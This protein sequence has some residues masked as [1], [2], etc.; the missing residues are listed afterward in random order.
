MS[1]AVEDDRATS[2][3]SSRPSPTAWQHGAG[4]P[5]MGN[6]VTGCGPPRVGRA[7][8]PNSSLG[9][10]RQGLLRTRL[11]HG[12]D[13][14]AHGVPASTHLIQHTWNRLIADF[15]GAIRKGDAALR[16][17]PHLPTLTALRS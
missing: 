5:L 17:Y 12:L 2:R 3:S 14:T 1:T 16:N 9:A 10:F 7:V 4:L 11:R 6:A 13:A 15:V 8:L